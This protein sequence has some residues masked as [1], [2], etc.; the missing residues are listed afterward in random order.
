MPDKCIF[1]PRKMVGFHGKVSFSHEGLIFNFL[2]EAKMFYGQSGEERVC[3][4][5]AKKMALKNY[6]KCNRGLVEQGKGGAKVNWKAFLLAEGRTDS[7]EYG[8][9]EAEIWSLMGHLLLHLG[10]FSTHARGN[11]VITYS[12]H[13]N[14][15][16]EFSPWVKKV[17]FTRKEDA[18]DYAILKWGSRS[19]EYYQ[20]WKI[21]EE[22]SLGEALE[23]I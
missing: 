16:P 6:T 7:E 10:I 3:P 13:T 23:E 21:G 15:N 12:N 9:K 1:C 19:P 14:F 2:P 22:L 8:R 18:L 11:W 20:L 5:C 17:Y 4:E